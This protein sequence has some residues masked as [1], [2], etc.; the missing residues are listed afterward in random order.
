MTTP[1]RT[2]DEPVTRCHG[3]PSAQQTHERPATAPRIRCEIWSGASK[4]GSSPPAEKRVCG[5]QS[6]VWQFH[7]WC[8]HRNRPRQTLGLESILG[9]VDSCQCILRTEG[10]HICILVIKVSIHTIAAACERLSSCLACICF[11]NV[12]LNWGHGEA[13]LISERVACPWPAKVPTFLLLALLRLNN[14]VDRPGRES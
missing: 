2:I 12:D 8:G 10:I 1:P 7:T 6:S 4:S 5:V 11:H 9:A 13:W 3:K 14:G